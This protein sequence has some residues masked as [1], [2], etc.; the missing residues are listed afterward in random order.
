MYYSALSHLIMYYCVLS[1]LRFF[2]VN[3]HQ[4]IR[5][6]YTNIHPTAVTYKFTSNCINNRLYVFPPVL[7]FQNVKYNTR[8]CTGGIPSRSSAGYSAVRLPVRISPG[9][10]LP[11]PCRCYLLH[12]T[13][14]TYGY[15]VHSAPSGSS[16]DKYIIRIKRTV[17]T[18]VIAG[19][20][21]KKEGFTPSSSAP[22]CAPSLPLSGLTC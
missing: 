4:S 20:R 21:R 14:T 10:V 1:R 12:Y 16:D 3:T 7:F 9:I 5:I 11:D 6:P 8:S 22:P 13:L 19:K 15:S 18:P 2:L 17:K